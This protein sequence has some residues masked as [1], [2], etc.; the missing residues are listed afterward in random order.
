MPW[1][2]S[3][4]SLYLAND[5]IS[6][7]SFREE[8]TSY[9]SKSFQISVACSKSVRGAQRVDHC[10]ATKNWTSS[11]R[12]LLR[13]LISLSSRMWDS[14]LVQYLTFFLLSLSASSAADV[15]TVCMTVQHAL[16]EMSLQHGYQLYLKLG[17]LQR[18]TQ[19]VMLKFE[20]PEETT[21]FTGPIFCKMEARNTHLFAGEHVYSSIT[22]QKT[23]LGNLRLSRN[24]SEIYI[25]LKLCGW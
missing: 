6:S 17:L 8:F 14:I 19:T 21:T 2:R 13:E 3:C 20:V 16:M 7:L 18:G 4:L 11:P 12:T 23:G 1:L 15:F 10:K 22:V 9:S 5:C 25:D 24:H